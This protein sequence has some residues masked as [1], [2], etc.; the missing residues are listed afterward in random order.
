MIHS[1]S[2]LGLGLEVFRGGAGG[3]VAGEDGL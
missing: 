2:L 1:L 3:K